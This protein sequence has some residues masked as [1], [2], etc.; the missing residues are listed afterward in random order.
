MDLTFFDQPWMW[1]VIFV[2]VLGLCI[3][4]GARRGAVRAVSGIAGTVLGV[5]LA[6]IFMD[7]LAQLL[8]PMIR[9][10]LLRLT[11]K[12]DLTQVTGLRPGT[13]LAALVEEGSALTDKVGELYQD[14][15]RRLAE[16]LSQS[17]APILAF[18]LIFVLAKLLIWMLCRLF[19]LEIPILSG[20]NRTAGG[21]LGALSGV[22]LILAL[23]WAVLSFAP[24]DEVGLLSRGCFARSFAG[25]FLS[26]LFIR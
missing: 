15:L 19:D 7:P 4:G 26:S 6:R 24:Q 8:E 22:L 23:S 5:V 14:L 21:I 11:E 25:G 20:L 12:L 17:L 3:W 9:P 13:Q 16:L 10:S 1:D 2:L 18:I